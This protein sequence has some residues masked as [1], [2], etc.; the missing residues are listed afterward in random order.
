MFRYQQPQLLG[1]F[2]LPRA[3]RNAEALLALRDTSI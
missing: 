1:M 2:Y 3:T